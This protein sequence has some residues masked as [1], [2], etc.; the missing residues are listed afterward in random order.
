MGAALLAVAAILLI[1]ASWFAPAPSGRATLLAHRGVHQLYDRRGLERDTCT[2]TRMLPPTNPYLENTIP[3]MRAS[4]AL[5]ADM[6]EID[7]HPTTDGDFA[8]FHDWTVEC[9]SNG[10]GTTRE[11]PMSYL[12]TLDIGWGYTAD[13]GKTYPF[14]GKG[15]GLMPTLA[16]VL[17]SFP[18]RRFLLNFKSRDPHEADLLKAYLDTHRIDSA[19]RLMVYGDQAPVQRFRQLSRGA[20]GFSKESVKRCSTD[21][22]AWGWTGV[23]PDSCKGGVIAVPVNMRYLVWGW[24]NRFLQRMQAAGTTVIVFG[25]VGS[26]NGAPGI[27]TPAELAVVPPGLHGIVWA[28]AIETIGPAWTA[29]QALNASSD[30]VS[31]ASAAPHRPRPADRPDR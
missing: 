6:L 10:R 15:V 12:K 29:R 16:E 13:G 30:P 28:D 26:G 31:S 23:V 4:F 11:L 20:P 18:E 27:T 17:R 2:A 3:S 9:R 7:I 8:V 25:P 19:R 21:Y 22:L 5:G 24:P 14:R 1:N